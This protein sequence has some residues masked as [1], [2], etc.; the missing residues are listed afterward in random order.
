MMLIICDKNPIRAAELVPD[1]LKFKQQFLGIVKNIKILPM[2]L[3]PNYQLMWQQQNIK[4][5]WCG[6][7][8]NKRIIYWYLTHIGEII[9]VI[10]H[11]KRSHKFK[12]KERTKNERY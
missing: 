6:K 1:R 3:I 5:M 9:G 7:V 12:K 8:K 4:N 10:V 11:H 2:L